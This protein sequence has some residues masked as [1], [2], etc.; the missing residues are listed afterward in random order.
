MS[1]P[2]RNGNGSAVSGGPRRARILLASSV[3]PS[4]DPRITFRTAGSLGAAGMAVV[5][6]TAG[7]PP[8]MPA[9]IRWVEL[10]G[11]RPRRL[12]QVAGLA[13]RLRPDVI[14]LHD[15]ELLL[16]GVPL[17]VAGRRRG[18]PAVV[19][20]LHEDLP[21]RASALG[22]IPARLTRTALRL[23][24][25]LMTVT[26]AEASYTTIF[27]RRPVLLPNHP[28]YAT[29]PPLPT[30]DAVADRAGLI[31]LGDVTRVRGAMEMVDAAAASGMELRLIGR[32]RAELA[33]VLRERAARRG[34]VLQLDGWM[35][36][37]EALA[38]VS[39][40][41]VAMCPLHDVP[42][43]RRSLPT[44]VLEYLALGVPVVA[45]DLPR[46]REVVAGLPGVT[47]VGAGEASALA[48]GIAAARQP[49]QAAA[50]IAGAAAIRA[51]FR[52][53]DDEV[54]ALYARLAAR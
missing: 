17:A 14:A 39:R 10:R 24:E 12:L 54:V 35:P 49:A 18:R 52:W 43:Y 32:V 8:T 5:L 45:S 21:A 48:A 30:P 37:P 27:R 15:P 41:A 3:H 6:A 9:G 4:E 46:T 47:L 42:N 1:P 23:V 20:D 36:H 34:V 28:R 29:F 51:R 19:F 2:A 31:Y 22:R 26:V 16:L 38:A 50:A 53:P 33:A 40:A 11:G 25:R 7:P 13:R 44:K